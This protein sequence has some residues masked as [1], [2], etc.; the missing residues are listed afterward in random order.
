MRRIKGTIVIVIFL[1]HSALF[2]GT[3]GAACVTSNIANPCVEN[4]W[5]F[6]A[7]ALYLQTTYDTDHSDN[8]T[9]TNGQ[10][11]I[12]VDRP[13]PW[14][15]GFYVDGAYHFGTANDATIE[16]YH[17]N[18]KTTQ[19]F[20][21]DGWVPGHP[22]TPATIIGSFNPEWDAVNMMLGQSLVLTDR[23]QLRLSGGAQYVRLKGSDLYLSGV[24]GGPID[25]QS[26][27]SVSYNGFG[28][29]IGLDLWFNLGSGF[30]IYDKAAASILV[31]TNKFNDAF[32]AFGGPVTATDYEGRT[33]VV[34]EGDMMLGVMYT[35]AFSS[36]EW[37]LDAGY[38]W[39]N[40]QKNLTGVEGPYKVSALSTND[41]S[42]NGVYFGLKWLGNMA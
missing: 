8:G 14:A 7:K 27:G 16:W 21:A 32:G 1:Y 10:H 40:Y 41:L 28:A 29:R 6:S 31:G 35:K 20:L 3:M 19:T 26:S 34:P 5:R 22:N 18:Q 15:W 39:V 12:L 9:Y 37:S 25:T 30:K 17:Y 24:V 2:A 11:S 13:T 36:G 23:T 33:A 4:A 38:M 42:L